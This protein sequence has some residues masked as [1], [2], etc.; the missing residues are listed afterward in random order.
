MGRSRAGT[1]QLKSVKTTFEIIE[2]LKHNGRGSVTE[3]AAELDAP[4]STIHTHLTTLNQI[5]YLVNDEGTYRL[6]FRFVHLGRVIEDSH[7]LRRIVSSTV[8]NLAEATGEQ[9]YFAVEENGLATNIVVEEGANSIQRE[10]RPGGQARMTNTATGKAILAFLPSERVDDI[11]RQWGMPAR[12]QHTITSRDEL[13]RELESIREEGIAYA[14][15]ESIDGLLEVAK[16]ILSED[17]HPLGAI[18]IAGPIKRLNNEEYR[19]T[20]VQEIAEAVNEI[21]VNLSLS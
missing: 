18:E 6:G 5:G 8:E 14:R 20:I 10:F 19:R 7:E 15:G 21:E 13:T 1:K 16:P 2:Y 17:D 12:T 11:V 4:K 3:I 9:A